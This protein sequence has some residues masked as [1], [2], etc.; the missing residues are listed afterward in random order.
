MPP[1][2]L[3][4]ILNTALPPL[5]REARAVVE[6]ATG[7][8]SRARQSISHDVQRFVE[9][10]VGIGLHFPSSDSSDVGSRRAAAATCAC[11]GAQVVTGHRA[12]T[13]AGRLGG[14]LTDRPLP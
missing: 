3:V 11:A 1:L 13:S 10:R 4:T 7:R 9:P 2:P 8:H 12:A 6:R 14:P 5:T